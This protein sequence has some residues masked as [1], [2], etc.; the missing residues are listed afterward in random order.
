M[1]LLCRKAG[2]ELAR[3][4]VHDRATVSQK[5]LGADDRASNLFE[6]MRARR[7]LHGRKFVLIDDVVTTGA[8]F[9]EAARA[10]REAGGEVVGGAALAF[11]PRIFGAQRALYGHSQNT[12]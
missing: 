1:S 8:T 5:T 3:V 9:F 4:L 7:P 6:S 12:P 2:I 10:L 11:T